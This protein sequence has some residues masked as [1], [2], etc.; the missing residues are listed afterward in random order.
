MLPVICIASFLFLVLIFRSYT[1]APGSSSWSASSLQKIGLGELGEHKDESITIIAPGSEDPFSPDNSTSAIAEESDIAKDVELG[2]KPDSSIFRPGVP[3][4]RSST[5]TRMLITPRTKAEKQKFEW[6]HE[7]FPPG[8]PHLNV[9]EYIADDPSAPLHPPKNKGHEVMIYLTHIINNYD[10]LADINI[11]MHNHQFAWHNNDLL[12]QDAAQMLQR[13]SSERVV[14]EGF[15]NLRCHWQPGCPDWMH[16]GATEIDIN[17]KE[18]V[19]M[20]AAWSELFPMDEIPSVLAGACC[21]QFAISRERIRSLPL[22]RYVFAR[23]WLLRTPLDDF[24]SGRVWE[25]VW[26]YLFTGS[27]V[28]C[29]L[30]HICYCD[31]YGLC[32]GSKEKYDEF[33]NVIHDKDHNKGELKKWKE[34]DLKSKEALEEGAEGTEIEVPKFGE[35]QRL[36]KQIQKQERWLKR[37]K[38]EAFENGN[39][40]EFRAKECGRPW[41][42]GDGF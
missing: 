24:I 11:F 12:G 41:K 38:E 20:A 22:S 9:S 3:K 19:I 10:S 13:L 14:R 5:Y 4:P 31:G 32:F 1:S 2:K 34:M 6:F 27:N 39:D 36:V 29:P 30:E 18:E 26:H 35:D 42:E 37:R 40:P 33:F 15:M 8:N 23:D 16:P 25:Y 21:A 7:H 28:H 17:K